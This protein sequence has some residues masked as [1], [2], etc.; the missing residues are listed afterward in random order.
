MRDNAIVKLLSLRL[1]LMRYSSIQCIDVLSLPTFIIIVLIRYGH[2]KVVEFL[3]NGNHCQAN[4]ANY[5]G[6]TALHLALR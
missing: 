4:A 6:E 3:V 2:L 5:N 1:C